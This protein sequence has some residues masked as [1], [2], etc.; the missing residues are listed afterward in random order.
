MIAAGEAQA[1]DVTAVKADS[2]TAERRRCEEEEAGAG[3]VV[4]GQCSA[5][6]RAGKRAYGRTAMYI[7]SR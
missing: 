5:L 7:D 2:Q 1:L 6:L 3:C 4:R